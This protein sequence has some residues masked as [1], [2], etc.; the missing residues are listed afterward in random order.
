MTSPVPAPASGTGTHTVGPHLLISSAETAAALAPIL[1]ALPPLSDTLLVLAAAPDAAPRLRHTLHDLV[2]LARERGA[3]RLLLAASGLAA[4]GPDG[5]RPVRAVATAADFTVIAPDGVASVEPDGTLRLAEP[6]TWWLAEPGQE[7]YE[8]GPGWPPEAAETAAPE[9][10]GEVEELLPPPSPP[11]PVVAVSQGG[12]HGFGP[13]TAEEQQEGARAVPGGIWLGSLPD[14][15]G[16][17]I[18]VTPDTFLLG[19]GSPARPALPTAELLARVPEAAADARH[20]LLAAPWADPSDLVAMAVALADDLDRTV[21]AAIGL[22]VRTA[23][24]HATT[25][26][27]G[28][29]APTWQPLLLELAASPA[30]HRV[31]PSAWLRPSGPEAKAPALYACTDPAGWAAELVPAGLWL[32]PADRQPD[33][34][35][36]TRRPDPARPV[37]IVGDGEHPLP[38]ELLHAL[39]GVLASLPDLGA[40][41][42]YGLLFHGA[43]PDKHRARS[44]AEELNLHWLGSTSLSSPHR[45]REQEQEQAPDEAPDEAPEQEPE[46]APATPAPA[47]PAPATPA[48]ATSAPA[49]PA[50]APEPSIT[51]PAPGGRSGPGDRAALRELLGEKYHILASK[52]E[53]LASRLPSLRSLAQDGLKADLVAIA[54]YQADAPDL[55]SRAGLA[56]A[57]RAAGPVP[58]TPLLRCLDSGLRRLP[59]HYGAV[60]LAAPAEGVPL[61]RYAQGSVLVEPAAVAAV[62]ACDAELEGAVE[63]GIWST[64]G[65]RT[66]VFLGTDDEPEVVFPPGTAF[67]VLALHL[68][69]DDA[70]PIRVLLREISSAETDRTDDRFRRRDEQARTRLTEWFERRDM[71][72]P[73]DRRPLPDASRFHVAPGA[74]PGARVR[75]TCL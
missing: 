7:P 57:A 70:A 10:A 27:D 36:R 54:L 42:P 64:T 56:E 55:G 18:G 24:G 38:P 34:A 26:L 2:L 21:R 43:T 45:E 52:A 40:T 50:P 66:S 16:P 67:S 71:L 51:P 8:L 6:G 14:A 75:Q 1:D 23:D 20:L 30:H 12:A 48:P 35:P 29:G 61:D 53:L 31:V 60:M 49:T 37:L 13:A 72:E 5:A 11:V 4:P 9:T 65:R 59:G 22:P 63:F 69:E 46:P 62:P 33:A 73:H 39:P 68:P 47:T 44:W 41:E 25:F 19:V 3:S 15:V 17:L 58:F 32:R 28:R 74:G